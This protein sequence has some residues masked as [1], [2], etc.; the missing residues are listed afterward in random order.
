VA[1]WKPSRL[2]G[3]AMGLAMALL[4][5]ALDG[6]SLFHLT[7]SPITLLSFFEGLLVVLSLPILATLGYWLYGLFNLRYLLDR[8][9]LVIVWAGTRQIIPLNRITR[10]VRGETIGEEVKMQGIKWPGYHIAYGQVEGLG[11][12]LSYSTRPLRDQL[13]LVTNPLPIIEGRSPSEP[14]PFLMKGQGLTILGEG[15]LPATGGE[16]VHQVPPTI[17]YGISPSDPKGFLADFELR[18][19]LG[20]IRPLRQRSIQARFVTLPFW[21][22]RISHLLLALGSVANAALFAYIC[23]IYPTLPRF[24]PLHFDALGQVVRIGPRSEIL[25]LPACGLIM[26]LLNSVLGFWV[27]SRE[28]LAAYLLFAAAI[29]V[30]A[31]LWVATLNIVH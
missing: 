30:Q 6:L 20:P 29:L 17:T 10:V 27:F 23:S 9:G 25:L 19:R 18:R 31:L 11:L 13:L 16:S 7:H 3:A 24:L 26:L 28:R 2:K 14:S 12:V 15:S 4:V 5:L 8:N 1:K 21:R 22:D